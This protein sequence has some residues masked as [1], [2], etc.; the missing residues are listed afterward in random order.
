MTTVWYLL[1]PI[2]LL[3]LAGIWV[4]SIQDALRSHRAWFWVLLVVFLP[5]LA[6]PAYYLNFFLLAR[7]DGRGAFDANWHDWRR[8]RELHR[9]LETNDAPGVREELAMVELHRGQPREALAHLKEV[10]ERDEESLRPQF[11]AGRAFM[12]LGQPDRALPHLEYVVEEDPRYALG[13]ARML[14]AE[15]FGRTGQKDRARRELDE[16]NA[17]TTYP[18][19]VVRRAELFLEDGD[20]DAARA[21]LLEMLGNAGHLPRERKIAGRRWIKRAA[22]LLRTEAKG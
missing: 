13:E 22:E 6:V 20:Q 1:Q 17:Y 18:Q 19:A 10:L 9:Q 3:I 16:L 4:W 5:P 15:A 12:D 11:L 14:L 2:L 7:P 21:I 8:A